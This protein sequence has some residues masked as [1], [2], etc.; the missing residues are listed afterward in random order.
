M[1]QCAGG[2][3]TKRQSSTRPSQIQLQNVIRGETNIAAVCLVV[4]LVLSG[5]LWVWSYRSLYGDGSNLLLEI[6][7]TGTF[8][9]F[10]VARSSAHFITQLPV[11][12][13][14][15]AGVRSI[16]VLARLYTLGMACLPIICY[17]TATWLSRKD[18]LLFAGTAVIILGCFY[19]MSCLLVGEANVYLAL[20]WLSFIL[21]LSER[22]GS[23]RFAVILFLAS[24]AAVKAYETSLVLSLLLAILCFAELRRPA[25]RVSR[26]II[27]LAAVL[28]VAGAWFGA[29]GTFLPRDAGNES[30]FISALLRTWENGTYEA[31]VLLTLVGVAAA[32]AQHPALRFGIAG[33][34][35]CGFA[36][37]AYSRLQM[38]AQLALGYV[39]DQ[40]AQ[41]FVLA[42]AVTLT[43]VLAKKFAQLTVAPCRFHPL[44]VAVPIVALVGLDSYDSVGFRTF[45]DGTCVQLALEESRQNLRFLETPLAKKFGWNWTLPIISVLVRPPGNRRLMID[46]RYHGWYRFSPTQQFPELDKFK[47]DG[48]ICPA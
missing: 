38:P 42:S 45:L 14:L 15:R 13:A 9:H 19:P 23:P 43:L 31:I 4:V 40:R 10:A 2:L 3:S 28:F 18:P 1:A 8:L 22:T 25:P 37:F 36:L 6:V 39:V 7:E 20:F 5:C 33:I 12:L 11:V 48:S 27:F 32:F 29:E 47:R 17:A 44:V 35:T 30:G 26:L 46:P 24:L 16:A 34:T 41:A 21:L